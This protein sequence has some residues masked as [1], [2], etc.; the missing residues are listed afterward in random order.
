MN[1]PHT[2]SR[3]VP[4]GVGEPT[5]PDG[6]ISCAIADYGVIAYITQTSQSGG[7]FFLYKHA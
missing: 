1:G 2:G 4:S 3:A 7:T 6:I 5:L